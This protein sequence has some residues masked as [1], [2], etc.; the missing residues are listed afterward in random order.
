MNGTVQS[1]FG[2]IRPSSRKERPRQS[3]PKITSPNFQL[4]RS[5]AS[6]KRAAQQLRRAPAKRPVVAAPHCFSAPVN[7]DA[8]GSSVIAESQ[9]LWYQTAAPAAEEVLW[10][11]SCG[12][13]GDAGSGCALPLKT[14]A[15]RPQLWSHRRTSSSSG[16]YA[17]ATQPR[18]P[19]HLQWPAKAA[20]NSRCASTSRAGP[21]IV[22]QRDDPRDRASSGVH[23]A[24]G[25][26]QPASAH[27]APMRE[28][29]YT[30]HARVRGFRQRPQAWFAAA[31][32][33]SAQPGAPS[34][35]GVLRIA[36][37]I[38]AGRVNS[39]RGRIRQL[40]ASRWLSAASGMGRRWSRW[41]RRPRK[42]GTSGR[43]NTASRPLISRG[44]KRHHE[45]FVH[46][47]VWR[48]RRAASYLDTSRW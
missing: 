37:L 40:T 43:A 13:A 21:P 22:Q 36:P 25:R 44:K 5:K 19:L 7:C 8:C 35:P 11:P 16:G 12:Q 31:I 47:R 39:R 1:I 4:R 28:L 48:V 17:A 24:T 2:Q 3:Q 23:S 38:K 34:G 42:T 9:P 32:F 29:R 6:R 18:H 26:A 27:K 46:R 30:A 45:G 20:G 10:L 14:P 41:T 33:F 15:A